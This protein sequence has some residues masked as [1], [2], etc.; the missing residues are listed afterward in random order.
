MLPRPFVLLCVPTWSFWRK[1][2]W[3]NW[4]FVWPLSSDQ[5]RILASKAGLGQCLFWHPSFFLQPRECKSLHLGPDPGCSL[6]LSLCWQYSWVCCLVRLWTP[7]TLASSPENVLPCRFF[8]VWGKKLWTH[9]PCVNDIGATLPPLEQVP[10][11]PV[12]CCFLSPTTAGGFCFWLV[13]AGPLLVVF[14]LPTLPC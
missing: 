11:C 5:V 9:R 14:L 6:W 3:Q 8:S 1:M 7:W 2:E 4:D 13:S 10:G 12:F